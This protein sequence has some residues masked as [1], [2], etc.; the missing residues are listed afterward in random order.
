MKRAMKDKPQ[1]QTETTHCIVE[2]EWTPPQMRSSGYKCP[3]E[4]SPAVTGLPCMVLSLREF[5]S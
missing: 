2:S 3:T 4:L 5:L 1:D